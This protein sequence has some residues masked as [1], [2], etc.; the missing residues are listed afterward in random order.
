MKS[1]LGLFSC[2]I[3]S[4]TSFSQE[5][6]KPLSSN[7]NYFYTDLQAKKTEQNSGTALKTQSVSLQ[8]PFTEDFYYADR[9]NFP[10]MHLWAD[11]NVYVNTGM[12]IAPPSIGV[13]T[14]DGLD[15]FGYPYEPNFTNTQEPRPADTLTSRPINLFQSG[16]QLLQP[17]DSI[18][19]SFYYQARGNGEPPEAG[20]SLLLDF[21]NPSAK[22]WVSNVW[23]A[24]G[25]SNPNTND[26]VFKRAFVWID[27]LKFLKDSF[28]FRFRNKATTSGNYDHWHIDYVYLNKNRSKLADTTYND[29]TFAS[30]P[31]TFLQNYSAMPYQQYKAAEMATKNSVRIKNNGAQSINMSYENRFY[32]QN[33]TQIHTYSGGADGNLEPFRTDGYSDFPQHANPGFGYTF[34][35]MNDSTDYTIKHFL[36]RSVGS[37]PDFIL[38]NDTV[39]QKQVF[40]NYFAYDDGS[41]EGGFYVNTLGNFKGRFALRFSINNL[42]TLRAVRIYFDPASALNNAQLYN[43]FRLMVWADGGVVPNN[44]IYRDSVWLPKYYD[45]VFFKG[46]PEYKLTSKLVLAPGSYFIGIQQEITSGIAIGFDKN[47]DFHKNLYYDSG[48]GWTQSELPGSLLFRPVFGKYVPP[49]VSVSDSQI[50]PLPTYLVYPNPTSDKITIY[51]QQHENF[52]YTLVNSTGK[53]VHEENSISNQHDFSCTDLPDGLYILLLKQENKT[54]QQQKIIIQH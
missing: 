4:F 14:F 24:K 9:T 31:S 41:A 2:G 15:K 32:N 43:R 37:S 35:P 12:P 36:Y 42:D 39:Y 5:G 13:A 29:L 7:L 1:L 46:V 48:G 50:T 53:R 18:G 26:T 22:E 30:V 17:S 47:S 20:D 27:S 10:R 6:L 16:A 28:Q 21:Y 25:N 23:F 51:H 49:P 19:F 8:I 52:S 54:V 38:N 40:K 3:I 33:A 11:S 34:P 45:S 44:V